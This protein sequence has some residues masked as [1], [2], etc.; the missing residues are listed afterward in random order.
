VEAKELVASAIA[1]AQADLEEALSELERLPA[2]DAGSVA[3]A[4]H[5]LNNYLT[6]TEGTVDLILMR[7]ADHPDAQI[8]AWLEGVQH[9][10]R[11]MSRT[12]SQ[13]MNV[14]VNTE[15]ALRFEE[16]ELPGLVQRV[17]AFYQRL[18]DRK[19]IRI[20]ADSSGDVPAVWADRVAIAAALDNLLSNAIKYSQPGKQVRVR[21]QAEQGWAVCGV[22]DEGPGLSQEDQAKLF[23]RGIRL[24]PKPTGGE[25]QMGYGLAVAREFIERL[26]GQIW[27]ESVLGQGSCFA[28]RLP[29]CR[30]R[31]PGSSAELPG[32][33]AGGGEPDR[34]R[35]CT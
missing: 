21:V 27:C 14:S 6:I 9:A 29:A 11:L 31:G 20:L 24:T 3:F 7:L 32:P 5:A 12:V 30:G 35:R 10:A 34:T 17:C 18:A 15:I 16:V 8:R 4:A 33:P 26:G 28:F 1:R 13:L 19:A 22:H 23:R 2:V 25:P